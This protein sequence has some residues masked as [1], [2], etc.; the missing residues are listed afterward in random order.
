M[1]GDTGTN[2]L[3]VLVIMLLLCVAANLGDNVNYFTGR[4]LGVRALNSKSRWINPR[5]IEK[6]QAFYER[7]GAKTIVIARFIPIV[8]TF[9]PFVAGFGRMKYS[10]FMTFSVAG[11]V[12]W[13]FF[14]TLAGYFFGNIPMIR[15]NFGLVVIGIIVVSVMPAVIEVWREWSKRA[16]QQ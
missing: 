4:K 10:K 12:F 8:R 13:V 9:A 15:K 2:G 6:T 3:N 7:Y 5:H 11:G 14:V 16:K 1:L